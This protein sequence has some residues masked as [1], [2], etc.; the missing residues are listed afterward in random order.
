MFWCL[1]WGSNPGITFNKPTHYLLDYG[2][3]LEVICRLRKAIHQ[4]RIELWKN[5]LWILH[6]D[7]LAANTSMLV[8]E[9]LAKNKTVI[10]PQ[11][12][13]STDL[14]PAESTAH[15]SMF[16]RE[17]LSKN[18]TVVMP[19][20]LYSTDLAPRWLSPFPKTEDSDA[21]KAFCDDWGDKRKI[22]TGAVGD[23][24]KHISKGFRRVGGYFEG[25]KLVIDK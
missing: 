11:S 9:F 13:Y 16:V 7:N 18:K 17:F 6:H 14:V 22:E 2:N 4:K 15:T 3:Y 8:R 12:P 24:K 10:M 23:I 20:P 21:R 1:V 25:H 19:Q 5:Q